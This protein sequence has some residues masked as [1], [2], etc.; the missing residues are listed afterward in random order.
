MERIRSILDNQELD[1]IVMEADA[2]L[3]IHGRD[4]LVGRILMKG[5]G[6]RLVCHFNFMPDELQGIINEKW[7]PGLHGYRRIRHGFE[8]PFYDQ[9]SLDAFEAIIHAIHGRKILAE[10]WY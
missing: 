1:F 8:L 5:S 6:S 7:V 2:G 3:E 10:T 9:L 4:A